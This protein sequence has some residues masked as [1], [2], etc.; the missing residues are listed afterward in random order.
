MASGAVRPYQTVKAGVHGTDTVTLGEELCSWWLY[1][2]RV[3]G[4]TSVLLAR[5]HGLGEGH[6][7]S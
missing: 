2:L 6:G 1:R 7:K 5:E 3:N 4:A